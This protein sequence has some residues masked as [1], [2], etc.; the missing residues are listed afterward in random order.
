M[1]GRR[2]IGEM[3]AKCRK[4][5][6]IRCPP[7]I[8]FG[9]VKIGI[10]IKMV[11]SLRRRKTIHPL[12]RGDAAIPEIDRIAQL[13][14]LRSHRRRIGLAQTARNIVDMLPDL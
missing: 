6:C 1:H 13:L 4:E 10:A 8:H 11:E 14:K 5:L 3:L 2:L 12:P 7:R 9:G